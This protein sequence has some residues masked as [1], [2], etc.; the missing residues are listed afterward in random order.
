MEDQ[1][2]KLAAIVFTDIVSFTKL[3]A[4]D[5]QKASDLLDTQ[6]A[7]LKPIVESYQGKWVKEMGDGLILTFDTVNKAVHCCIKLQDKAKTI[8]NLSLRIGIHLGEILEK[9]NDIIGDDVNITSRIEPF[10]APGGIA[11]S[12]KVNDTII[13]ETDFKTKYLGKPKLKGVGQKVEVY[14]IISHGLPETKLSEVSA[15]LEKSPALFYSAIGAAVAIPLFIYLLMFQQKGVESIAVLYLDVNRQELNYLQSIT[16]DLI[17]DLTSS[18]QG[19]LSVIEAAQVKEYI[20]S[21]LSL[22]AIADDIGAD[23]I[24]QSSIQPDNNGYQLRC[25]LFDS[26]KNQDRLINKWFIESKNLQSIVGVLVDNIIKELDIQMSD[27]YTRLE[28]N[29]EAYDLYLQSKNIYALSDDYEDD[30]RA[31]ELMKES[32]SKDENLVVAQIFLGQM[33]YELGYFDEASIIYENALIKSKSLQDNSGIAES[34]R[35]QGQLFRKNKD[36][37]GAISK[38]GEA[39]AISTVMNDKNSMAK[40]FN[41][42]AIL[43]YKIKDKDNALKNWLQALTIVEGLDDKL[44]ESKY[45]NNIGI[46]YWDDDDY[47]KAIEYYEKSLLIKEELGDVRNIGKTTNN[48]GEVYFEMGDYINSIEHFNKSI[49]IKEKLQ[50]KKGLYST[51]FNR[52]ETYFYSL[53]Y[54]N[55]M[56]DFR[57]AIN[58]DGNKNHPYENYRY[59]GM[60]H[61]YLSNFDSCNFY[62]QQSSEFYSKDKRKVSSILPFLAISYNETGAKTLS[63]NAINNL[64]EIISEVDPYDK[65]Y[66]IT[67]WVAFEALNILNK[68]S[69]A[70]AFLENAYFELRS[71]SKN[72]KAKSDRNKY[73]NTNLH[74]KINNAWSKKD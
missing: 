48:L 38:F 56:N 57:R 1:T 29:P 64:L 24:F 28:Y 5:Q 62:L 46:W 4:K 15:K 69:D 23:Y 35:K 9:E 49:N 65:D 50:D 73:L 74:N 3:T 42:M 45:L 41:S 71:R 18:S 54:N 61:F 51:L 19:L 14:C 55:A 10:S 68:K 53:D 2:R 47:S 52:G 16:E 66:V 33:K 30:L 60:S 27:S 7:E 26:N 70:R 11:I 63:E 21:D 6:R 25:R 32:I 39:L 36:Y 37:E 8:E 20:N 12:N 67:N 34:L 44:K 40:T 31:V 22:D 58:V 17:F 72:I 43:Y 13:R 59:L